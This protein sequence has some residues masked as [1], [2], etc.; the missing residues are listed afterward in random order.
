[1]REKTANDSLHKWAGLVLDTIFALMVIL[2][3]AGLFYEAF[4]R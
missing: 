1:M 4:H 3:I 2:S